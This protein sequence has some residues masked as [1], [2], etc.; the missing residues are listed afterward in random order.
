MHSF[1]G[2]YTILSKK[3]MVDILPFGVKIVDNNISIA[4]VTSGEDYNFEFLG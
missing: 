4:R 2:L 3:A 1:W